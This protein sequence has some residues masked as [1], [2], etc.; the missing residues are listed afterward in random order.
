M[1]IVNV[2]LTF[3][4][5]AGQVCGYTAASL[6]LST[7]RALGKS[8]EN[9]FFFRPE[10]NE[11]DTAKTTCMSSQNL[12]NDLST[13]SVTQ[14][15]YI[16]NNLY[17]CNT[18][19]IL[20]YFTMISTLKRILSNNFHQMRSKNVSLTFP[21]VDGQVCGYT[22]ASLALGTFRALGRSPKNLFFFR[23]EKNEAD[24]AKKKVKSQGEATVASPLLHAAMISSHIHR[25]AQVCPILR[26]Q[27]CK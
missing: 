13:P 16:E 1:K 3:P 8:P 7:F 6:A 9:L 18:F 25:I 2:S 21:G 22:A 10:K 4:G 14:T 5:V 11:A 15:N 23:P 20:P 24:T 26:P 12:G 17:S 27:A 19:T